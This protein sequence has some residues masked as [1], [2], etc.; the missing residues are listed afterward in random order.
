M[1]RI[2]EVVGPDI[3]IDEFVA[4]THGLLSDLLAVSCTSTSIVPRHALHAI[5]RCVSYACV[6]ARAHAAHS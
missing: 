6:C 3:S 2:A 4:A 5:A 1:E